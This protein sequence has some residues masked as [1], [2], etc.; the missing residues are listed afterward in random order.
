V[1]A[2]ERY[3]EDRAKPQFSI[4]GIGASA[5]GFE[6]F[7]QLLRH[8]PDD[9]GMAFVLI[10][11]LDPDHASKL[12]ELLSR[13]SPIPVRE[14]TNGM[15]VEPNHIYAIPQNVD[16][17]L[18]GGQLRLTPRKDGLHM[19]IDLF[20]RSLAE[21]LN[22]LAI[23]VVLSG[24]GT[25]GTLGVQE[26]KGSGGITFAQEEAS[27]KFFGMPGSAIATG[28]IDF[29]LPTEKIGQ[30][31]G[32]MARH[33]LLRRVTV[34]TRKTEADA[35]AEESEIFHERDHELGAIFGLLRSRTAVD[36]SLYKHTTLKRRILRRMVLHKIDA[37]PDYLK[38]LK[39]NPAEV[40]A[41]FNDIL[42]NVTSF[43]RDPQA[44]QTLQKKTLPKLMK[45]G[46]GD[47]PLRAWVCGCST[48]EEAYSL[49]MAFCEFME[50][51]H[52][53]REV[54]IFA[55]DI[56]EVAL[57]RARA[58]IYPENIRLDV[59]PARLRRFFVQSNGNYQVNKVIRDI[60]VFA[61]QNVLVD[62]PFSHMDIISCR[63][64]LIYF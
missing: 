39:S 27:A 54:Q 12:S 45:S 6:A 64:V 32:R 58:G 63:N 50:E 9:T 40:D 23:G 29:V 41:L 19:P 31:L 16:L 5:G 24:N 61:R 3:S 11:H 52:S 30:E 48:G 49:A 37:L 15:R 14:V 38:M 20:F 46:R 43:F 17:R 26:I 53:R 1:Q 33:P 60:C 56:S 21:E 42:I 51:T 25:D 55:T 59:S 22:D 28:C 35:A 47:A 18:D 13:I 4:V 44:F 10:Q 2:D 36:F 57:D 7:G 34:A 62:P 8:L